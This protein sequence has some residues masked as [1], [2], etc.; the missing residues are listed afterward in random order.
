[1]GVQNKV[2]ST[3]RTFVG[4]PK[5]TNK[6]LTS[7]PLA[8]TL[9]SSRLRPEVPRS[10]LSCLRLRSQVQKIKHLPYPGMHLFK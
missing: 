8:F 7:L 6:Y 2:V 4:I 3:T 1:M 9:A 5:L 10:V